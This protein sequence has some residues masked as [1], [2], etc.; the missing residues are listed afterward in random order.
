[1]AEN[2]SAMQAESHCWIYASNRHR[3]MY[4]YLAREDG[5]EVV[6]K[7]LLQRF[8]RPR[9]VMQLQL[10]PQRSL[11]REDITRVRDH[12]QSRGYHLQ[13]PPSL[14]PHLTHGE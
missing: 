8:G 13:L 12:L 3:E 11:V 14:D 9:L 1:M 7:T 5:F 2:H 4:L 10:G 6:P